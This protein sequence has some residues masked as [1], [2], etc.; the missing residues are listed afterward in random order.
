MTIN[1]KKWHIQY[2]RKPVMCNYCFLKTTN[3]TDI[4][5]HLHYDNETPNKIEITLITNKMCRECWFKSESECELDF[6]ICKER[7]QQAKK[8]GYYEN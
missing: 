2:D 7:E 1:N 8:E 6:E 3:Y 4:L 5:G